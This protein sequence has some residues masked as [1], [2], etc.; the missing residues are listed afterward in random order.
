MS[1]LYSTNNCISSLIERKKWKKVNKT[2]RPSK[3]VKNGS[4]ICER[5]IGESS[6]LHLACKF[7][8]PL[9]IVCNF[10]ALDSLHASQMDSN[11]RYALHLAV[12]Y[13]SSVEVVQFL[14]ERH[15][16]SAEARDIYGQTPLCIA[17]QQCKEKWQRQF[18]D[19][20]EISLQSTYM[21]NIIDL[22]CDAYP[23]LPLVEDKNEMTVLEYA[24]IA[25][26]DWKVIHA[27]IQK[28]KKAHYFKVKKNR[29]EALSS[30]GAKGYAA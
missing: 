19:H 25:E 13:Q 22:L 10:C 20:T 9:Y 5:C 26:V 15:A 12:E 7:K 23:A 6:L 30:Q 21:I 17:V 24:I 16:V 4:C 14:I 28:M 27:L 3:K 1:C 11:G 29:S 18:M 8:P 2:I